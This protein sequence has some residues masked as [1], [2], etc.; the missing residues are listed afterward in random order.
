M[1]ESVWP[2]PAATISGVVPFLDGSRQSAPAATSICI[3]STS[4]Y[5]AASQNARRAGMIPR[6][7][8]SRRGGTAGPAA[9][10]AHRGSR[11]A[12]SAPSAGRACRSRPRGAARSWPNVSAWLT[13]APRSTSRMATALVAARLG[14]QAIIS[15]RHTG[16]AGRGKEQRALPGRR[17]VV[18]PGAGREQQPGRLG[19]AFTRREHQRREP[20]VRRG[21]DIGAVVD[22]RP[23]PRRDASRP[24]PTSA[25]SGRGAFRAR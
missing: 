19:I 16:H 15:R 23:S 11:R 17:D 5:I 20:A 13:F 6:A 24:R 8:H 1:R 21:V 2:R 7:T 22:E 10:A 12:R 18:E 9:S 25:R 14:D 3:V 4:P